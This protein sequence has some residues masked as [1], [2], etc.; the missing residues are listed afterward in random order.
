MPTFKTDDGIEISY[1]RLGDGPAK[2]VFVHGWSVS[3][4]VWDD[5][6]E[7][8]DLAGL[9]VLVPDQRGTGASGKPES[10]YTIERYAQDVLAL[11]DHAG[12]DRFAVV[13]HSMGGQIAQ[14]VAATAPARVTKLL[15]MC[16][17]PAS[18]TEMPADAAAL[19]RTSGGSRDKTRTILGLACR[20]LEPAVLERML[21]DA[22][23][24]APAAVEGGY[25][26]WTGASFTEK[27]GA[28][29]APTVVLATDDPFLPVPFLRDGI[30]SK[31]ANAR[32]AYLPG[33][34]HYPQRERPKETAALL[35]TFLSGVA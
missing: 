11:A 33:P 8:F 30:V 29:T 31:I 27:L 22:A 2:V 15:L 20:Q 35:Q 23:T 12:F 1:R 9:T 19:F 3:G 34:G 13:G 25:D 16:S 24:V 7:V 21:D 6:L 4:G 5:L 28:I 10:G 17:V 32:L 18:G 14:W 26:A